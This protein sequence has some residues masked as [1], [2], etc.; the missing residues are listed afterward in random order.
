[1]DNYPNVFTNLPTTT[2]N[3][4]FIATIKQALEEEEGATYMEGTAQEQG[5]VEVTGMDWLN[6]GEKGK[7]KYGEG[8][9]I[10]LACNAVYTKP[11]SC[12]NLERLCELGVTLDTYMEVPVA[13]NG[14]LVYNTILADGMITRYEI[15]DNET[16]AMFASLNNNGLT[17]KVFNPNTGY[18]TYKLRYVYPID[19]DGH[20]AQ[21][22]AYTSM[23]EFKTY[24]WQDP[25]Y[26]EYRFGPRYDS[27]NKLIM[28]YY[29]DEGGNNFSFPVF[30]NSF[31]FYF[32]IHEG[33][34]AIDKFNSRFYA[35]CYKNE[36]YPFTMLIT[37]EPAK[38]CAEQDTDYG[39]INIE[40]NGIKSPYSYKLVNEFN[41][42]I[43]EENGLYGD[44]KSHV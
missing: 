41:E 15:V 37:T 18:D 22:E 7:P 1:M 42:E 32:G 28:H 19:F 35:S 16:R 36:K 39:T 29:S 21:A 25:N 6:A 12:V 8:L 23:M 3:V 2:V 26:I 44:R 30:N 10:D 38:W 27:G 20:M 40:L 9:F 13:K 31:Y 43:L 24:D 5:F 34:T 17:E 14:T 11:K 4:P 33:S